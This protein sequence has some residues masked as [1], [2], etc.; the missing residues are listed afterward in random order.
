MVVSLQYLLCTSVLPFQVSVHTSLNTDYTVF[1]DVHTTFHR[2]TCPLDMTLSIS[3]DFNALGQQTSR[4]T[5]LYQRRFVFLGNVQ[6][7]VAHIAP[8][9]SFVLCIL[10]FLCL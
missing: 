10:K 6:V 9:I 8:L 5:Q 1:G 2:N 4:H 3:H 7:N